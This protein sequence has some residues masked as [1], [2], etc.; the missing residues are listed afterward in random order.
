MEISV[1]NLNDG[2]LRV[3]LLRPK[4]KAG[5]TVWFLF[6]GRPVQGMVVGYRV[7]V[8]ALG[9]VEAYTYKIG[10]VNITSEGYEPIFQV[11]P[12]ESLKETKEELF[13]ILF[14]NLEDSV[15]ELPAEYKPL[16]TEFMVGHQARN[17]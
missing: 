6:Q 8:F 13:E 16:F 7:D 17:G 12:E 14:K 5:A 11:V 10:F 1:N 4:F 3:E 9:K 2:G 15:V